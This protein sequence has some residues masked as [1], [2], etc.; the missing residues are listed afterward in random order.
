MQEPIINAQIL[1]L[2]ESATLAIN[3]KSKAL[4]KAGKKIFHFGF[5]QSPFPVCEPIQNQLKEHSDKKEYLPTLGLLELREEICKYYKDRSGYNFEPDCVLIGPGSKEL[6]FQTLFVLEGPLLI[7]A[8]S[9]VSYGP[10]AHIRGKPIHIIQT[11]REDSYKLQP[12]QL[13]KACT[14]L[15]VH[16]QKVLIVNNPNNPTGS[17]YTD[18]E[19][20][21]LAEVCR[22][23]DVIVISDEIYS[24]IDFSGNPYR[25]FAAHYPEGTIVTNGLSKGLSAGGYRLGFMV[26]P[27]NMRTLM[28]ALAAMVSETFSAVSAPTQYATVPAFSGHPEVESY[29]TDCTKVHEAAGKY[30]HTRFIDM[31]AECPKPEGAFYLFPDFTSFRK[32][33][34]K[35]GLDTSE[36]LCT[37]FLDQLGVAVLPGTDFYCQP[38]YLACRVATVDYDGEKVLAA[39]REQMAQGKKLDKEFIEVNCPNLK[40]GCDLLQGF[41]SSL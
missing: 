9:W 38:D 21:A 18:E 28:K 32:P 26:V 3:E 4:R 15:L 7:P 36:K 16:R 31:G 14:N 29:V 20:K 27:K 10:Q 35:L 11:K 1:G 8:P 41:L 25:G 33:L 30:L 5:G 24:L 37:Y 2:K 39:A 40:D 6:I 19:I 13:A 12:E 23:N 34:Q 17:V 22:E